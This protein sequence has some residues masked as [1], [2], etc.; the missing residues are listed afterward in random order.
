M[1]LG[2]SRGNGVSISPMLSGLTNRMR[3]WAAAVLTA[4]Y[5]TG[6][7]MPVAAF[8]FGEGAAHCLFEGSH[9][10]ST[11]VHADGTVH[12]HAAPPNNDVPDDGEQEKAAPVKC[13]GMV[14]LSVM[15]PQIGLTLSLPPVPEAA[16]ASPSD[17]LHGRNP[18]QLYRPPAALLTL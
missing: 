15:V 4:A 2:A 5:V 18:N 7:V 16:A 6:I 9:G 8:A 14:C 12:T 3:R 11:H 17:G 10:I 1:G 13:C